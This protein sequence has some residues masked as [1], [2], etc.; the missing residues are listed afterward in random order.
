[1]LVNKSMFPIQAGYNAISKM[2]GSLGDLQTQLGSGEKTSTLAGMGAD[3][4][5]SLSL[6]GRMTKLDSY[7]A[8]MTTVN[9]RLGFLDQAFTAL[10]TLKSEARTSAS[11]TSYGENN[12][13]MASLQQQSQNRLGLMLEAL[14]TN[15]GGRYL[16]GG[17]KTENPPVATM[18]AIMNGVAGQAGYK[19]VL[20]E[21]NRADLGADIT[22]SL[23]QLGLP[24]T[25][26]SGFRGN[27][28]TVS[29]K[30]FDKFGYQLVSVSGNT[31][32][33]QTSGPTAN[34][35]NQTAYFAAAPAD[36][37]TVTVT[38]KKTDGTVT[39]QAMKAVTTL[40]TT[41]A[42][43]HE[44]LIVAGDSA[45]SAANFQT[46][47]ESLVP[48]GNLDL[49]SSITT[50]T[51]SLPATIPPTAADN[52]K[53]IGDTDGSPSIGIKVKSTPVDGES[54][55]VSVKKADG[56][57]ET[58][59]LTAK[60]TLTAP[61]VAGEFL[62]GS[63]FA[64]TTTNLKAAL[65][66]SIG[67]LTS[68]IKTGRLDVSNVPSNTVT[69]TKN[70]GVFGYKALTSVSTTGS[71]ITL[72]PAPTPQ[73]AFTG[74]TQ[75]GDSVT[76][77]MDMPDGTSDTIRLEA[78]KKNPEVGQFVIG[79]T[80]EETAKNFASALKLQIDTTSKTKLVAASTYAAADD[81]FTS[82]GVPQRVYVN[83]ADPTATIENA[84]T[85]VG[86]TTGTVKWYIGE[87]SGNPRLSATAQ[88][89]DAT[90]VGY[91]VRANETGLLEMVRTLAA[92]SVQEYPVDDLTSKARFSA[93]VTR[94]IDN[95]SSDTAA[96]DG[97]VER[98]AMELGV[99][100]STIGNTTE[101][102]TAYAGQMETM[103]TDVETVSMEETA[104]KIMALQTRL[105]A[106]YQT[107]ASISQLSLVNYLK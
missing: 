58:L 17:N 37:D 107:T 63:T 9:M 75:A 76:F 20:S 95:L 3:R 13:T 40:S 91:G 23:S 41:P 42:D 8:N 46:S 81:F 45:A 79:A 102:N 30:E 67:A 38:M 66:S 52:A 71:N 69:L 29:S 2:Q 97:S 15:V 50:A 48:G 80:P 78:V 98:I 88:I 4:S 26:I 106:S 49:F 65:E 24:R 22:Q 47:L 72:G 36:G 94:Q 84:T 85:L 31:S 83:P 99:V 34:P 59:K 96:Q 27:N 77:G 32:N 53:I 5:F 14:N 68:S 21:R 73:V 19:Q 60:T 93:M 86:D 33:I 55:T 16:M 43:P 25:N 64:E 62:I 6:R 54:F 70:P 39:T 100:K 12:I 105:Q 92:M 104:M 57:T 101:R 35:L 61:P 89:D 10:N 28:L 44:F 51:T 56:T 87:M 11:P 18:D 103:L 1:M 82:D 7:S 74:P 90:K